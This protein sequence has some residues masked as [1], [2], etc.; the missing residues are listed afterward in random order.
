MGEGLFI[1]YSAG[2]ITTFSLESVGA[3]AKRGDSISKPASGNINSEW[4]PPNLKWPT[5]VSLLL[6]T[7]G[8]GPGI[9]DYAMADYAMGNGARFLL[10]YTAFSRV[11]K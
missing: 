4:E 1:P 5:V 9:A 8:N 6:P 7:V 10:Y 2:S 3:K 11:Q